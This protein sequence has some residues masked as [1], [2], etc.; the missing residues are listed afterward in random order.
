MLMPRIPAALNDRLPD[1][2]SILSRIICWP[3]S[4]QQLMI[5]TNQEGVSLPGHTIKSFDEFGDEGARD[6]AAR[7]DAK[8]HPE[9]ATKPSSSSP[10]T[11]GFEDISLYSYGIRWRRYGEGSSSFQ[12]ASCHRQFMGLP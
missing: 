8:R 5:L 1:L 9:D 7:N 3:R 6:D 4:Q 12:S 10:D 2:F 11:I